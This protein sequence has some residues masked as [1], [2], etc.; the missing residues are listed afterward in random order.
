MVMGVF[1]LI[2]CGQNSGKDLVAKNVGVLGEA[3]F[4]EGGMVGTYIG[5][6]NAESQPNG[7][8]YFQYENGSVYMGTYKN[9]IRNGLGIAIFSTRE[10]YLR[11]FDNGKMLSDEAKN[12]WRL[13]QEDGQFDERYA[14]YVGA[15]DVVGYQGFGMLTFEN[16]D[17]YYGEFKD[18]HR[19]GNGTFCNA[20]TSQ[21]FSHTY[22]NNY[23]KK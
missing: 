15:V 16:G 11:N 19:H 10:I 5:C 2:G 3:D 20:Q 12:N 23:L 6:L 13:V 18:G 17:V 14:T 8:G 9:G 4:D 21:C 1:A 7:H 22:V